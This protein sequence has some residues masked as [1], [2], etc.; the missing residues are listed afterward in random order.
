MKPKKKTVNVVNVYWVFPIL[1][2]HPP[3]QKEVEEY[4]HKLKMQHFQS[5]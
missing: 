5:L 3:P 4:S 2:N 1:P